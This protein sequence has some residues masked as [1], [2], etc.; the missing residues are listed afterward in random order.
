[1]RRNKEKGISEPGQSTDGGGTDL[2]RIF[3]ICSFKKFVK[4]GQTFFLCCRLDKYA[5]QIHYLVQKVTIAL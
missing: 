1:M 3:H 4:N 5:F 2:N